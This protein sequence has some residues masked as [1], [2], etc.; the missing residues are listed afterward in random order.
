MSGSHTRGP[1]QSSQ[2]P[3]A[4]A[5]ERIPA[6]QA[7]TQA[8]PRRPESI[9]QEQTRDLMAGLRSLGF[10]ASEARRAVEFC[11][12]LLDATLEEQ[13]RAALKFLC[14]ASG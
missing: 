13:V 7:P 2:P 1:I 6:V 11:G 8:A 4:T 9:P 12:T 14:P 3:T 5:Q 10:R